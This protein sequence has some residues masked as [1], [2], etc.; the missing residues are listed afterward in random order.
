MLRAFFHLSRP[1]A[2]L[3]FPGCGAENLILEYRVTEYSMSKPTEFLICSVH[4]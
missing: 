2:A 4:K 3:R 1:S